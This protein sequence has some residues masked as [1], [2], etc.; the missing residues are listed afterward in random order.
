MTTVRTPLQRE[1]ST[2]ITQAFMAAMTDSAVGST[3]PY[4]QEDTYRTSGLR[5]CS[6]LCARQPIEVKAHVTEFSFHLMVPEY[7][8][9]YRIDQSVEIK[10]LQQHGLS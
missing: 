6:C 5:T 9:G 7:L 2:A 8:Q 1:G 4:S 3:S 10:F